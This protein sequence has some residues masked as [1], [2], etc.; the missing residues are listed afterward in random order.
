MPTNEIIYSDVIRGLGGLDRM[1]D[2]V[3]GD[4]PFNIGHDYTGFEDAMAPRAYEQFTLQWI[5]SAWAHVATGGVLVLHGSVKMRPLYWRALVKLDLDKHYENEVVWHYRFG[6]H[7]DTDW[8]D[9]HCPWII[10]RKP[11]DRKWWADD[12]LVESDRKSKYGDSRITK[13]SRSGM[14]VPGTV[15]S[16]A[17]MGRVQ[18]NSKERWPGHPNQLPQRIIARAIKA[19][20]RPG[21]SVLDL[22]SGS[23]T[24]S[25]VAKALERSSIAFEMSLQSVES[26]RKRLDQGF[27]REGL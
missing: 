20:T 7:R 4:P 24:V 5:D 21:G 13:S 19:Y 14:R 9:M 27:V 18:G 11:G 6:Q 2:F 25:V 22:F 8:I 15:W 10:L 16:G 17:C 26:G 12:V 23:A 1:F 3:F